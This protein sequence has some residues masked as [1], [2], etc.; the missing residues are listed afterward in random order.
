MYCSVITN[1]ACRR[2][3]TS[4]MKEKRRMSDTRNA[5]LRFTL[6]GDPRPGSRALLSTKARL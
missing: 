4:E 2:F 5:I 6:A 1:D 3:A